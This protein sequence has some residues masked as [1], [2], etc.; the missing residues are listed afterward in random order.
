MEEGAQKLTISICGVGFTPNL[1]ELFFN[2]RFLILR[3][4]VIQ[5]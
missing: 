2:F 4:F 5:N 1:L 3:K